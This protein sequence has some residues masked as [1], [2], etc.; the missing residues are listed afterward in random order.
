MTNGKRSTRT[1]A[2]IVPPWLRRALV[3]AGSIGVVIGI[4][5]VTQSAVG[6]WPLSLGLVSVLTGLLANR[7][8]AVQGESFRA[9]IALGFFVLGIAFVYSA[10][11]EIANGEPGAATL[12]IGG[13]VA[14]LYVA[15]GWLVGLIAEERVR[16][17]KGGSM[18]RWAAR[19]WRPKGNG[20]KR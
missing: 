6:F 1:T 3:V 7:L 17:G 20:G 16:S 19:V 14:A 13:A 10:T 12:S 2:I 8:A 15:F 5:L 18:S 9:V 4:A 11:T